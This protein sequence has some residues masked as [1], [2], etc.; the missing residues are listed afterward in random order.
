M[1][2]GPRPVAQ[3]IEAL[4]DL[5]VAPSPPKETRQMRRARERAEAK[6][7]TSKVAYND[8]DAQQVGLE[9]GT[10][11]CTDVGNAEYFAAQHGRD[12]RFDHRRG[13]WLLWQGHRWQP[14]T[15]AEIRRRAKATVRQR[16]RKAA[17]L[18]DLDDR[19]RLAKWSL[20]SLTAPLSLLSQNRRR[21]KMR[22][23]E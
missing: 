6:L 7:A 4:D 20:T 13:R 5:L 21:A 15:D 3:E 11:R 23:C 10:F 16:F 9:A 22:C 18:N 1:K 12:V 17:A 14:D 2:T 8:C 19:A